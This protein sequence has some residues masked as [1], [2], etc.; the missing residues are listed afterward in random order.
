MVHILNLKYA[1]VLSKKSPA[2]GQILTNV[3]GDFEI[4]DE[5]ILTVRGE[6]QKTVTTIYS[7]K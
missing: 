6:N 1:C 4:L 3:L 2:I 5:S 7:K